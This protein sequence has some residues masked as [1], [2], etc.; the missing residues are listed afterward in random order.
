MDGA[1]IVNI[2]DT[3]DYDVLVCRGTKFGNPF[4]H[5]DLGGTKA[6]IRVKS[7]EEAIRCYEKW[8][9]GLLEVR[10]KTPPTIEEIR[11]ELSGRILGCYCFP[12]SCHAEILMKICSWPESEIGTRTSSL[13]EK[14]KENLD[15]F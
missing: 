13:I 6:D 5:L 8:I 14:Y 12:K 3:D 7:R 15:L 1:K 9:L 11:K 2:R 4:T 10:G